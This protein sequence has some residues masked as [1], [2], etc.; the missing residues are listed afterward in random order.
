[1][2]Y[3]VIFSPDINQSDVVTYDDKTQTFELNKT[4]DTDENL[5][6]LYMYML[7]KFPTHGIKVVTELR[8]V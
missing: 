7:P 4:N 6:V 1:M 2:S 8:L 5:I 3:R